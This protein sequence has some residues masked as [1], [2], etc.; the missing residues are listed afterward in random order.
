MTITLP[1]AVDVD[2][3]EVDPGEGC[4]DTPDAAARRT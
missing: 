4:C 1:E 3:F 2:H